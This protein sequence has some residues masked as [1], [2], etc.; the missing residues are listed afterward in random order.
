[1]DEPIFEAEPSPVSRKWMFVVAVVGLVG[2]MTWWG[3]RDGGLRRSGRGR[4]G[5]S[6][7][8]R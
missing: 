6:R 2:L 5:I 4:S 3:I 8:R 7:H 1:M